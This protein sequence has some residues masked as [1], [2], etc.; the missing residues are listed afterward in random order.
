MPQKTLAETLAARETVYVHCGHPACCK[1]TKLDVQTLID[2]LGP[3]HG[4]MH[5]DLVRI[6]A[7]SHCKA[8]GRDRRPVFFTFIPDYEGQQGERNRD[9][10]PTFDRT[11]PA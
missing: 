6:F 9:W 11:K 4:S 10:K 1:S 5:D 8:A 7:C 2:R 3:D